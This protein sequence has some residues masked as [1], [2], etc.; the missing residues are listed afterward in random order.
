MRTIRRIR[1]VG[2][3]E[4]LIAVVFVATGGLAIYTSSMQLQRESVWGSEKILIEGMLSDLVEFCRSQ[5]FE[6]L[7]TFPTPGQPMGPDQTALINDHA[8]L[9][10]ASYFITSDPSNPPPQ[11]DLDADPFVTEFN[12]RFQMLQI[13]RT[14][15]FEEKPAASGRGVVTC[16]IDYKSQTGPTIKRERR[17]VIYKQN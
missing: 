16:R 11:A 15:S 13:K 17:L 8:A 9:N 10:A 6:V 4:V 3:I 1:G 7:K 5:D 14:I 2:L 12:A